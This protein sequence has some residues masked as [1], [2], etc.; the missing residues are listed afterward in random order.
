MRKKEERNRSEGLA[1]E[2]RRGFNIHQNLAKKIP[3][4]IPLKSK[5]VGPNMGWNEGARGK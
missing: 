2:R 1:F 4:D 5:W 3:I